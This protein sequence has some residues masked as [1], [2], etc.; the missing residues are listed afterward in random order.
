MYIKNKNIIIKIICLLFLFSNISHA[1]EMDFKGELQFNNELP[2]YIQTPKKDLKE[3]KRVDKYLLQ[4]FNKRINGTYSY[5]GY[6]EKGNEKSFRNK[7]KNALDNPNEYVVPSGT[8][9]GGDASLGIL[10]RPTLDPK[11]TMSSHFGWRYLPGGFGALPDKCQFHGG[12][13]IGG[14][15]VVRK[16][17]IAAAGGKVIISERSSGDFSSY[18]NRIVIKHG[19]NLYTLYAH[20]SKRLVKVGETVQSGQVIGIMGRTGKS[21]YSY[22]EHLHFE[23]LVSSDTGKYRYKRDPLKYLNVK[24]IDARGKNFINNSNNCKNKHVDTDNKYY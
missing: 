3:D 23:V 11:G 2:Q 14:K 4:Q 1:A 12:V 18:G 19:E 21:D 6:R 5:S 17:I 16:E 10:G 13:D 9:N 8:D 22:A 7:I 20:L 24:L 15:S